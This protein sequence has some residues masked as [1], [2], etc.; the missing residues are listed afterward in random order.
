MSKITLIQRFS[1]L[2][3]AA[4][5][6][7]AVAFGIVVTNFIEQNMITRSKQVTANF[8]AHEIINEFAAEEF[9]SPKSGAM[10]DVYQKKI[11][12][13]SLGP[14]IERI[15]IWDKEKTVIWADLKELVGKSYPDNDDIDEAFEGKIVSELKRLTKTEHEFEHEFERLLELYIPI[16]FTPHG[17]IETVIE[18]YKNLDPLYEDISDSNRIV[19][20]TVF[21][22]FAFLYLVLFGI[23]LRAS[24]RI[25]SQTRDIERSE[26]RYRNLVDSAI[27]GIIS[28][29]NMGKIVLFNKAAEQIFGYDLQE[30]IGKDLNA[31]MTEDYRT[32]HEYAVKEFFKTGKGSHVGRIV[33]M[34]GLRK[35]GDRFPLELALSF[36]GEG[37][38]RFATGIIRDISERKTLQE[39]L[40]LTERQASAA[41]L[42]GSI[43]HELNNVISVLSGYSELL[44]EKPE[45]KELAAKC[46]ET[47]YTQSERLKMHAHNLLALS[48]PKKPEMKEFDLAS[49]IDKITELLNFSGT[50]KMFSINKQYS[51]GLP[52]VLG[53]EAQLEQVVRNLEINSAHAMGTSGIL[54]I[55]TAL[56]K[57]RKYVVFSVTDTGHGIPDDKRNQIFLPFF[58]TKE[59]GKGTGLGMYITKQVVDQH[60]GYI[61]VESKVGVG[62]TIRIGIP[63]NK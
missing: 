35:N 1:F 29:N 34:E 47:F 50:L 62:T 37:P 23:M 59:K 26:E 32:R 25:E 55:K 40:I 49:L 27:D 45:D 11:S 3:L 36:S 52:R 51:D 58:T 20:A 10:Y 63:V 31:I 38:D 53:D 21:I 41:I 61:D 15:K 7:F 54:T 57:D 18:I 48:K 28:I 8:I 30:I 17:D 12:H 6:F 9:K 44:K 60:K 19:W 13:L 2:C 42:A 33:E 14:N 43:G 39:Q 56:S 16:K 5:A 46:A 24:K 22:G 4:M